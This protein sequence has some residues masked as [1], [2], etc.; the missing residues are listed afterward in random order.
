MTNMKTLTQNQISKLQELLFIAATDDYDREYDT[1]EG[2]D[3]VRGDAHESDCTTMEYRA[4]Y[5]DAFGSWTD[6]YAARLNA[7]LAQYELDRTGMVKCDICF[8]TVNQY[9]LR[10]HMNDNPECKEIHKEL[11]HSMSNY[12]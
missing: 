5:D 12:V 8:K 2:C 10:R 6:E 1:C 9:G 7:E 4:L 11:L 3:S